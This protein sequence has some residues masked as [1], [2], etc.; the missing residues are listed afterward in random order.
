MKLYRL[1]G[2]RSAD[3]G[4]VTEYFHSRDEAVTF[5]QGLPDGIYLIVKL[6]R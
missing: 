1:T 2:I 6:P 5:M 4:E 3:G